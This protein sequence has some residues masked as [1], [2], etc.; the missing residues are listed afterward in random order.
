[1]SETRTLVKTSEDGLKTYEIKDDTG[2]VIGY[3]YVSPTE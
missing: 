2:K 1:M 3:E